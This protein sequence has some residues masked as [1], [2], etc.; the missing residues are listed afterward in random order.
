MGAPPS[1]AARRQASEQRILWAARALFGE[2]GYERAT[3]RAIAA[4]AGVDPALVMQHYGSKR[5]LF[6]AAVRAAPEPAFSG[7]DGEL[8]DFLTATLRLKLTESAQAPM[9]MLRSM[10]T[11]PEATDRAR[12]VLDRQAEQIAA[13][14]PADDARLRGAVI[15]SLMIGVRVGRELL[16]LTELADAEPERV[17]ELMR[18]AF[19][20]LSDPGPSS[21]RPSVGRTD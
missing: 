20:A 4:Q 2:R 8:V 19:A 11:H 14:I 13:A 7:H 5:Q 1:R 9:A 6:T 16:E 12:E 17:A 15:A 10:L 21:H 3:I 18:A